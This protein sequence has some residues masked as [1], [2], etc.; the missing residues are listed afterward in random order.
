MPKGCQT[1]TSQGSVRRLKGAAERAISLLDKES[2]LRI[3][4]AQ[5]AKQRR[6]RQ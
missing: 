2:W 3:K 4:L 6:G 1:K 5:E